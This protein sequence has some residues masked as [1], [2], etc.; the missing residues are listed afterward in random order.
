[1]RRFGQGT[2]GASLVRHEPARGSGH[3]SLDFSLRSAAIWLRVLKKGE[4][5]L[6]R[7]RVTGW[8]KRRG[9]REM[10]LDGMEQ[11]KIRAM[12]YDDLDAIV[13]IDTRVLGRSRPE[14]WQITPLSTGEIGGC[15]SSLMPWV[16]QGGGHDQPGV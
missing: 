6:D 4:I 16:S 2:A 10:V 13:D 15:S 1:M 5:P 7:H 3:N 12:R 8:P 9:G 14:Y 11:Y